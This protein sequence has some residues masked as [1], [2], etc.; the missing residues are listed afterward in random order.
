MGVLQ[1]GYNVMCLGRRSWFNSSIDCQIY[2]QARS[3]LQKQQ[4]GNSQHRVGNSH[5]GPQSTPPSYRSEMGTDIQHLCDGSII[6]HPQ[7]F[8]E[9]ALDGATGMVHLHQPVRYV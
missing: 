5:H 9:D 8:G 6:A 3:G 4:M 1:A 2:D 7:G